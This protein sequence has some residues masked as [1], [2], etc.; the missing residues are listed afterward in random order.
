MSQVGLKTCA[1][2]ADSSQNSLRGISVG[3]SSSPHLILAS[4]RFLKSQI[5]VVQLKEPQGGLQPKHP[6]LASGAPA[7]L[8]ERTGFRR[9]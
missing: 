1:G 7:R 3:R 2:T 9:E 4:K 6:L 5:I 8:L